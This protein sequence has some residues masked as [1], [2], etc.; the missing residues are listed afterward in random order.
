MPC[1]LIP[2]ASGRSPDIRPPAGGVPVGDIP[3]INIRGFRLLICETQITTQL[4]RFAISI[5]SLFSL[6]FC[7]G[8]PCWAYRLSL[9]ISGNSF[10]PGSLFK[11]KFKEVQPD[12]RP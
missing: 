2:G 7:T 3:V 6:Q 12:S 4:A 1:C 8:A 10:N 9:D 11:T 5:A